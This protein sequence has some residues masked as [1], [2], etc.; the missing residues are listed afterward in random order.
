MLL[1]PSG[2][3]PLP[4]LDDQMGCGLVARHGDAQSRDR[5][6]L[7]GG[8]GGPCCVMR[9]RGVRGASEASEQQ[10]AIDGPDEGP[11]E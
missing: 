6:T 3:L 1:L 11:E 9:R 10:D 7:D 2:P 5:R 4:Q 8:G